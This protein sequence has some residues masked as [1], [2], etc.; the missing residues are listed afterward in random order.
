MADGAPGTGWMVQLWSKYAQNL[1][2]RAQIISG[3]EG[4]TF[5]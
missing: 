3:N 2:I 5:S 4:E 1:K